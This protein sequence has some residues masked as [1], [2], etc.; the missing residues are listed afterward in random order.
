M[1]DSLPDLGSDN[2]EPAPQQRDN[3]G[4]TAGSY[5]HQP[6][7]MH[8]P[9]LHQES[10]LQKLASFG[11][12]FTSA[13]PNHMQTDPTMFHQNHRGYESAP[14]PML[15]TNTTSTY[16]R[17]M[18]LPQQHDIRRA[19]PAGGNQYAPYCGPTDNLY[20]MDQSQG[21]ADTTLQGWNS[22]HAYPGPGPMRHYP[23]QM[24]PPNAYRQQHMYQQESSLA[25][26]QKLGQP[27]FGGSQQTLMSPMMSS[28]QSMAANSS[29]QRQQPCYPQQNMVYP[30]S[31]GYPGYNVHQQSPRM[32]PHHMQYPGQVDMGA[33]QPGAPYNHM[34]GLPSQMNHPGFPPQQQQMTRPI[35]IEVSGA[36][37]YPGS[38]TG[39]VSGPGP[40]AP[41]T[42]PSTPKPLNQ[43]SPQPQYR[44]PTAPFP[45]LSPQMSPRPNMSPRAQMSPRPVMSPAKPTTLSPHPHSQ[46][47]TLSPRPATALTPKANTA[48][49]GSYPQ[50][51][52]LQQLEQMVMPP[53]SGPASEYPSYRGGPQSTPPHWPPARPVNG[54]MGLMDQGMPPYMPQEESRAMEPPKSLPMPVPQMTGNM[55]PS[56]MPDMS[57]QS[58][59]PAVSDL[60]S[61]PSN[62]DFSPQQQQQV[63]H[64]LQQQHPL[65]PSPQQQTQHQQPNPVLPQ[66]QQQQPQ[67]K[68]S[69]PPHIPQTPL[70][71]EI[72]PPSI[73]MN[74]QMIPSP[75]APSANTIL[76]PVTGNMVPAPSSNYNSMQQYSNN[77]VEDMINPPVEQQ[78]MMSG[79]PDIGPPHQPPMY[80]V[81]NQVQPPMYQSPISH[82]Q[83][84]AALNQQLQETYCM[85]PTPEVQIR[86]SRH[87]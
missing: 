16:G 7:Q 13:A 19:P 17:A 68:F 47:T 69:S 62:N 87:L 15:S 30:G 3:A 42:A 18:S 81:S 46:Q 37:Q 67:E 63:Q 21:L 64:Q 27:Q 44:P 53:V 34:Q 1:L 51:S 79:P 25:S 8:Q 50:Q 61:G 32:P 55:G 39:S 26:Q 86:V 23:T 78:P 11:G 83:E 76:D 66:Q 29:Y 24:A 48:P 4:N 5:P 85:P 14:R 60:Q 71:N 77:K 73:D 20:G 70:S 49:S 82:Q 12:D 41:N 56:G 22:G 35:G 31:T 43:G 57:L 65:P 40:T 54:G 45:Q 72:S 80:P 36:S 38:N 6:Y 75:V 28:H 74:K 33:S 52:T 9:E 2:F 10:P 84:M 58:Q 59:A